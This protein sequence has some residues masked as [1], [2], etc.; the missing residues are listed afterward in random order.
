MIIE[1]NLTVTRA[2]DIVKRCLDIVLATLGLIVLSPTMGL[3]AFLIVWDS[4]GPILYIDERLGLNGKRFKLLKFRSM[5][6]HSPP[7]YAP[8]GSML[9]GENDPRV[10]RVG[11][12]LRHGFD[13]FPQFWNV[14]RGEMSVVGP[15]PDLPYALEL[16]QGEEVTRLTVRPGITGLAQVMG[17]TDIP[18]RERLA[19]DVDYVKRRSLWL[20]TQII[21]LTIFEF[22]PPIRHMRLGNRIRK[23]T[24]LN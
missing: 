19:Y 17:R 20:D 18:W 2:S 8:D 11:K 5:H 24:H 15:R 9:I 13:E 4:R 3:I 7:C 22:V 10:T 6:W 14:L 16:Y 12:F 23:S 1:G 21:F